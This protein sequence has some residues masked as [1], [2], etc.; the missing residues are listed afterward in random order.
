MNPLKIIYTFFIYSHELDED[1]FDLHVQSDEASF[2]FFVRVFFKDSTTCDFSREYIFFLCTCCACWARATNQGVYW[3]PPPQ[4]IKADPSRWYLG[5]CWACSNSRAFKA[6]STQQ[7]MYSSY[8]VFILPD[9]ESQIVKDFKRQQLHQVL[10]YQ[11]ISN[12]Q[13]YLGIHYHSVNAIN[14]ACCSSPSPPQPPPTGTLTLCR[15]KLTT[16]RET[17]WNH[18]LSKTVVLDHLRRF[19]YYHQFRPLATKGCLKKVPNVTCVRLHQY[20]T[21]K[22]KLKIKPTWDV[23]LTC[24]F[25]CCC[26]AHRLL[27]VFLV[28]L[29]FQAKSSH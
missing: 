3:F 20:Q 7:Q 1:D 18:W 22:V 17:G 6:Q 12:I 13:S 11:L 28:L 24:K 21:N 26:R 14:A 4:Y 23:Q 16:V 27:S 29:A 15:R 19:V 25:F 2:L 5:W 9:F 8:E 10:G